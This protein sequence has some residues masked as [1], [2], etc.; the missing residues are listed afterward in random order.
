MYIDASLMILVGHY[1]S[2]SID[3]F[4]QLC[5]FDLVLIGMISKGAFYI[6]SEA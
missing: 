6:F 4:F 5:V 2:T 1:L 3:I